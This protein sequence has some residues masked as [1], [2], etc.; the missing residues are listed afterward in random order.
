MASFF[1]LVFYHFMAVKIVKLRDNITYQLVNIMLGFVVFSCVWSGWR[2]DPTRIMLAK[3]FFGPVLCRKR[4]LVIRVFWCGR[5]FSVRGKT[6]A[7]LLYFFLIIVKSLQLHGRKQIAEP[8]KYCL[9][10]MIAFFNVYFLYFFFLFF[11]GWEFGLIPYIL[12]FHGQWKWE[13]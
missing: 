2:S 10:R 9:M 5:V 8:C 7:A 3:K 1:I 12:L 4:N 13:H 6:V 11:T